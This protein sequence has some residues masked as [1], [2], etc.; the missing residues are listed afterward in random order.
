MQAFQLVRV[1]HDG[2]LREPSLLTV[3]PRLA[4]Q[5][6]DYLT[7]TMLDFKSKA[8]S[9]APAMSSLLTTFSDSDL[10]SLADYLA[11]LTV[12]Q[13]SQTGEIH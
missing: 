4:G 13:S 2:K 5:K 3:L 7:Q 9:N 10:T 6:V 1:C 8:R 12:Y 11:S